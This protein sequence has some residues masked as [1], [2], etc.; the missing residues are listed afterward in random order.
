MLVRP[1]RLELGTLSLKVI[2]YYQLSYERKIKTN[3]IVQMII[4]NYVSEGIEP[5]TSSGWFAS[6][7]LTY[8]HHQ[9][10]LPRVER[11]LTI[12]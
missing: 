8:N 4:E 7:N 1:P 3:E 10:I 2:C 11:A 12:T 9:R 6:S 5:S